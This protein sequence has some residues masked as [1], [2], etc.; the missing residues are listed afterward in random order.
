MRATI[1]L[2][3]ILVIAILVGTMNAS[4][5]SVSPAPSARLPRASAAGEGTGP[6]LEVAWALS[7]SDA[8]P[9]GS[10]DGLGLDGEGNLYVADGNSHVQKFDA[11]GHRLVVWGGRGSEDGQFRCAL[12]G[13]AV[14]PDG[15]VYVTDTGNQRVQRFDRDGT[16]LRSW[17]SRGSGDGHFLAPFGIAAD[18]AGDVYVADPPLRRIQKFDREGTFLAGWG[19]PG[20]GDGQFSGDLADIAVDGNGDIHVTD[21]AN[22]LQTFDRELR[23]IARWRD[24]GDDRPILSATGVAVGPLGDVYVHD[25]GNGRICRFRS[26]GTPVAAY[27]GLDQPVGFIAVD[28]QGD[29]YLAQLS[30][31]VLKVRAR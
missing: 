23:F 31:V 25:L 21:R 19:S 22:G 3:P 7:P 4:A 2:P 18:R 20:S 10:P 27:G 15:N 14:D 28:R 17:G 11:D 29:L 30:G 26:D 13:L 12:C 6:D 16:F 9:F 24:C 5:A 1:P 8:Y